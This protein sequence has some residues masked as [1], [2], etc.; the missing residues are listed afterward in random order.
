VVFLSFEI[1]FRSDDEREGTS[2]FR[3]SGFPFLGCW[4]KKEKKEKL[5]SQQQHLGAAFF[6]AAPLA[7]NLSK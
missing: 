3:P 6:T 1:Y 2:S 7:S 5:S 4:A